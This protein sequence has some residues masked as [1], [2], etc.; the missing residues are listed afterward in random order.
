[1]QCGDCDGAVAAPQKL[2]ANPGDQLTELPPGGGV[3]SAA[4]PGCYHSIV[5]SLHCKSPQDWP[6]L[7]DGQL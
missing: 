7:Y 6:E 4:R 3:R 2:D 5:F 1:M